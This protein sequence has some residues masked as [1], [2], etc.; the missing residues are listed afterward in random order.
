M[1]EP[2]YRQLFRRTVRALAA[3]LVMVIVCYVW[4]DRPVAFYVHD[5]GLD[6]I[7]LFKW[8]TYPP[9]YVQKWS[10]LILTLLMI[11]RAWGPFSGWQHVLLIACISLIVADEFRTS[12]GDLCGRYWPDSW[13]KMADGRM[14]PS[15]IDTGTYGFHPFIEGDDLG[16]FPSGHTTRIFGFATV[17]WL[18]IPRSRWLWMIICPP[19][20]FSLVAMNYH[21]VSDVIAGGFLGAIVATY[22]AHIAGLQIPSSRPT[23]P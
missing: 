5:H 2:D 13:Y 3:C 4:V 19:M 17:W 22:F 6:K 9:P 10:P 8:L 15:L 7:A 23:L 16:S 1:C 12:L 20:L 14:N 21:F 18:A 11:R